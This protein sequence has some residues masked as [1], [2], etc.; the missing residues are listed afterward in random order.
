LPNPFNTATS[1]YTHHHLASLQFI[2]AEIQAC[3]RTD[4]SREKLEHARGHLQNWRSRITEKNAAENVPSLMLEYHKNLH[5]L[6]QP[7]IT[8]PSR[9][10]SDINECA[11]AAGAIC[12]LYKRIHQ[13]EPAGF[14]LLEMHDVVVAGITLI[15]CLWMEN[16]NNIDSSAIVIDLGACSTVLF[17]I[18]ERWES[19]KRYRDAFEVLVKATLDQKKRNTAIVQNVNHGQQ[20]VSNNT[21]LQVGSEG[22]ALLDTTLWGDDDD[23]G[24]RKM[25]GEMTGFSDQPV[26]DSNWWLNDNGFNFSI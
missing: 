22:M 9:Q 15:Y 4:F 10:P 8:S 14:Y 18:A 1:L 2:V 16:A 26:I 3:H 21:T 20:R 13:R 7:L 23:A 17:L 12:Q 25:L 19:A 5:L 6:L 11:E 24:W